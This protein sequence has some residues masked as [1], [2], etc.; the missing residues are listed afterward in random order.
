[1]VTLNYSSLDQLDMIC[2]RLTGEPI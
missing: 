1:V 2:Q